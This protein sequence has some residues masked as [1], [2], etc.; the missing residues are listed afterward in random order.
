VFWGGYLLLQFVQTA[1]NQS[2]L[3]CN[4]RVSPAREIDAFVATG[5][6]PRQLSVSQNHQP[7]HIGRNFDKRVFFLIHNFNLSFHRFCGLRVLWVDVKEIISFE[8]RLVC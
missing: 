7:I 1:F 8:N 3:F 5:K 6:Q 4:R 2:Q